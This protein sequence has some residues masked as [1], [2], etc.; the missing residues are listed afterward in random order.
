MVRQRW[1]VGDG[2]DEDLAAAA[3]NALW[4]NEILRRLDYG[5]IEVNVQ[6]GSVQLNGHVVTRMNKARAEAAVRSVMGVLHVENRLVV[7]DHLGLEVARAIGA[8]QRMTRQHVRV[9]VHHGFVV[10]SGQVGSTCVRDIAGE[11]AAGVPQVRGVANYLQAPDAVVKSD[12]CAFMQ[13]PMGR[14]VYATD[15]LLGNVERVIINPFDRTVASFAVRGRFPDPRF[16]GSGRFPD[17]IPQQ[18]R[19]VVVPIQVVSCGMDGSVFLD[20]RRT[21]AAQYRECDTTDFVSPSRKWQPPYPYRWS[22]VR[23][24]RENASEPSRPEASNSLRSGEKQPWPMPAAEDI[25]PGLF[26]RK[27][28]RTAAVA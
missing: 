3:V 11:L 9:G 2:P 26:D 16:P 4:A 14:E 15:G 13:P 25:Q 18:D 21:E 5:Q 19:C 22:D 7:D 1:E 12:K 23:F 27:A 24:E 20:I 8:D 10:L 28:D 6:A 17:E